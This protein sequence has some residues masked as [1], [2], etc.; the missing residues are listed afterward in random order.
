M[1]KVLYLYRTHVSGVVHM[2]IVIEYGSGV[3][4]AKEVMEKV[5][6]LGEVVHLK[7]RKNETV[8][9]ALKDADAFAFLGP[10]NPVTREMM[11]SSPK[12]KIAA[13]G[14]VGTDGI[15]KVAATELGV[16]V[17]NAPAVSANAVA[18]HA[19]ALVFACA[20]CVAQGD[21]ETRAGNGWGP[22]KTK[23]MTDG[24]HTELRGKTWGVVG[25][26]RIGE[27]AA[28]IANG[29]GCTVVYNKRNR[30]TPEQEK[31]LNVKYL[32]FEELLRVS[33][34]VSMHLPLTPE[35]TGIINSKTLKLMKPTA[36]I[37]NQSRGKVVDDDAIVEWL[38]KNPAAAYGTDVW[39]EEPAP[40]KHP[41]YELNNAVLTPHWAGGT[42][43]STVKA[44]MLVYEN[45][46][47]VLK[48]EDPPTPV[49]TEVLKNPKA[50]YKVQAPKR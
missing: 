22:W 43:D 19:V 21:R 18:E 32:P 42:R 14:G 30:L 4:M 24:R 9:A 12:L 41:L 33:D 17:T 2:K 49:N 44:G 45:L 23:T 34:V 15:D 39:A 8:M 25:L 6:T 46:A 7:D 11:A 36:I 1:S 5:K 38:K 37:E 27:Y 28:S 10:S 31:K 47:K 48:G 13:R 50:R 3:T 40:A 20:R 35:T 26:G 29:L 16:V